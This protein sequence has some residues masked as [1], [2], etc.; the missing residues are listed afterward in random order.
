MANGTSS[1]N[2]ECTAIGTAVDIVTTMK[3][4]R[5]PSGPQA[6][7]KVVKCTGMRVC[8]KFPLMQFP[9]DQVPFVAT[10]CPY[11]QSRRTMD[12]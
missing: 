9:L 1:K 12:I 2:F 5:G 7:G 6:F 10:G 11:I 4:L 3:P 8:L